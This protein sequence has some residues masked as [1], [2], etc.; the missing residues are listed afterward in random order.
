M[1]DVPKQKYHVRDLGTRSVN[2]F[3]TRAEVFRD[4]K[5]VQ[6]KSGPNQIILVGL[7]PTVD[8]QSIKVE[9]TG[10]AIIT[11]I[12]VQLLPNRDIFQDIYPDS[13][14]EESDSDSGSDEDYGDHEDSGELKAL[15]EQICLLRDEEKSAKEI[16][17]S[18]ET[19]LKILDDYSRMLTTYRKDQAAPSIEEGVET[20]RTERVKVFRD[21]MNGMIKSRE[22]SKKMDGLTKEENRLIKQ[23]DKEKAKAL[24]MKAKRLREKAMVIEKGTRRKREMLQ[25]RLR[26]RK[27]RESFWPRNVDTVKISLDVT[28]F[29]PIT[30]R[31]NSMA[32]DTVEAVPDKASEQGESDA[33]TISCDLSVSY[34]TTHAYWAPSYDLA[35]STTS[36][37]GHLCFD[38]RL[39]NMTSETWSNCK[40][41]LSTSQT[42]FSRLN[43]TIP[44]LVPWRVRLAG[45][46]SSGAY[47]DIMYSRDEQSHKAGWNEQTFRH[48]QKPRSD[49]FG[50]DGPYTTGSLFGQLPANNRGTEGLQRVQTNNQPQST[51][52]G[53]ANIQSSAGA[54]FGF[55]TT[56]RPAPPPAAP[57]SRRSDVYSLEIPETE[58]NCDEDEGYS[59]SFIEP[60][61]ELAFQ[62]STFE[63]TGF[64]STY[65]LPGLKTLAPS[66]TVSKQ[67]VARVTF[68]SVSFS[69]TVVAKYKPVAFL[70]AKL[71]N[72]SNLT[73]LK[74][75]TGLTLDVTFMGRTTLPRCSPGDTFTL[76]LGVDPA[77]Q[78]AYPKP[79][80]KRS[81]SGL[82]SKEDGVH[83]TR[84]ITLSNTRSG[85][86]GKPVQLTVLGQIPVS[87]DERLRIDILHPR[88]LV[89]GSVGVGA[90][91]PGREGKEEKDWGKA[92]AQLKKDGEVSWDVT[93]NAGRMV[94]LDLE[95]ECAFPAGD[96]VV[97]V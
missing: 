3:P 61:P 59:A 47:T 80:V 25:E 97:N 50:V 4:I 18:A 1:D 7:S 84:A 26:I 54:L 22:I 38:S 76:S 66:S 72:G 69:H 63:E 17:A 44:T 11:D 27:E 85:S 95:Y 20:Y 51:G 37:S 88:G 35:L 70:K 6:L 34:V 23:A 86:K 78:V 12:A 8:E 45:K 31:H 58:V 15:R 19:R 65:D 52:F 14:D 79:Q 13:D 32:S 57:V 74:G 62:D 60:Q 28:N 93:L 49:M 89:V 10:P 82:F 29:T 64:T 71:R 67:R 42:D 46:G 30:S 48:S 77:I 81:Q 56:A 94:K 91:V 41:I 90:G 92:V 24:K 9:G 87:E 39:T 83:Y 68:T 33:S 16:V 73:L 36:N 43:D 96:H 55:G 53:V 2:L 40:V 21:H 75:Q 5:D